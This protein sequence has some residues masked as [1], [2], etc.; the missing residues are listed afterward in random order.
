MSAMTFYLIFLPLCTL[1]EKEMF[2]GLLLTTA[3]EIGLHSW[4]CN[5]EGYY[6]GQ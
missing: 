5:C 3:E 4:A 6:D 2:P 1:G